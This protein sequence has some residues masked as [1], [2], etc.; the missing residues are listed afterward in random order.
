MEL[1]A[2]EVTRGAWKLLESMLKKDDAMIK[3]QDKREFEK[4]LAKRIS[5][6]VGLKKL[7]HNKGNQTQ[8]EPSIYCGNCRCHRYTE[9]GCQIQTRKEA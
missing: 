8:T 9:C 4:D 5:D 1:D 2:H 7:R 3:V 6:A